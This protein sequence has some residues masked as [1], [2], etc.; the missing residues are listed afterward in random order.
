[1]AMTALPYLLVAAIAPPGQ[2]FSGFMW[3]PDDQCVYLSW[4]EQARQ[5]HFFFRNLFTGDA[6]R[7]LYTNLYFWLLGVT[8]R[9]LHLPNP[10]IYHAGRV[11]FGIVTLALAYRLAAFLTVD[12]RQRRW[13]F[14]FVAFSA[15]LGWL[16]FFW[17]Q[18]GVSG[19]VDVWQPEAFTFACLYANGLFCV[20]LALMLGVVCLLLAAERHGQARYAVGAGALGF[21]L[22]NI[23]GYDVVTLA[24]V[25][26]AYLIAALAVARRLPSRAMGMALLAGVVA[27]P[28]VLYQGYV[29]LYE[30]V[31]Q[32]RVAVPTTSPAF[33][34]Y[35]L[36]Y[37][38]L[39][40]LAVVGAR[41]SLRPPSGP[42]LLLAVWSVV[43]FA[44]PYLPVSF[45][46]KMVMGLHLPLALLAAFGAVWLVD[47]HLGGARKHGRVQQ[48]VLVALLILLS[49]TS[50]RWIARDWNK[51]AVNQA[52]TGLHPVFW[53]DTE[54]AA[55]AWL[56]QG[57]GRR[58]VVLSSTITGSMIPA[59][60]GRAVY[61]GHWGETPDFTARFNEA[62]RFFR[63]DWPTELRLAFLRERGIT[64][65][66]VGQWERNI[67][68]APDPRTPGAPAPPPLDL[69]REPY[70]T[71]VYPAP[72]QPDPGP[73]GVVIYAVSG[74]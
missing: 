34:K 27:L 6:Q 65:V 56:R 61:V 17:E 21:L 41:A 74:G 64:H 50:P 19:P 38:L 13:G 20:S 57:V 30:P 11:F 63:L 5:G 1:M 48:G 42:A 3:N 60:A 49:L 35:L 12:T 40:P 47:R 29:F 23:H 39:L 45:Q 69:S 58:G 14:G 62:W 32:K 26:V 36:G 18:E 43:G 33:W 44:V 55:I 72:G 53:P 37:G 51:A 10:I 59:I 16:P 66:Y 22:A 2:T 9:L 8:A 54:I 71:R 28:S 52:S 4:M 24:V 70:L 25:W 15:G 68:L 73:E 46:R 7:G 67:R 31:F